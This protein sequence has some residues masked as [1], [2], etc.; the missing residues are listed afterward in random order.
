MHSFFVGLTPKQRYGLF[1]VINYERVAKREIIFKQGQ[2]GEKFYIVLCGSTEIKI[3]EPHSNVMKV[4]GRLYPG[5]H[6]GELALQEEGGGKL[7][8]IG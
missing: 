3:L 8:R 2:V 6:F 1:K 4:V 7:Y 5:Q